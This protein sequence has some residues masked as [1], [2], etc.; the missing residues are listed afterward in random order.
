MRWRF[1]WWWGI[2]VLLAALPAHSEWLNTPTTATWYVNGTTGSGLCATASQLPA[3]VAWSVGGDTW[4][5]AVAAAVSYVDDTGSGVC[6]VK[7]EYRLSQAMALLD[8]I[9]PTC[10]T[11]TGQAADTLG[12]AAKAAAVDRCI[13][14]SMRDLVHRYERSTQ[15]PPPE[16][17]S[18]ESP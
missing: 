4:A 18:L 5:Q 13:K 14:I 1:A 3:A 11:P 8:V 6:E 9:A 12:T 15:A 2:A 7:I 10:T 17:V 16:P